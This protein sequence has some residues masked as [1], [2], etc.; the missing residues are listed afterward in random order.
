MYAIGEKAK[1]D[2]LKMCSIF[3]TS[4][5]SI[6]HTEKGEGG[7]GGGGGELVP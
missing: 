2:V 1:L 5:H 6:Y 4:Y 7:G 3:T